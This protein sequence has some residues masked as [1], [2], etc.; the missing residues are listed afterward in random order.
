MI[1]DT[2]SLRAF[3]DRCTDYDF[4]TIDTEFHRER[5]YYSQLCL[6]QIA[7][8]GDGDESAVL[9]DTL[10]PDLELAP[11]YDLFA[12]PDVV[13]VFHAARQDLEIFFVEAG[14]F[15]KP[16]FDTQVAAMVCGFGE[17][18]GYETLVRKI[19]KASLDKSSR[20]TDWTQRPLT[21]KQQAYALAD[22]THLRGIYTF[23]KDELEKTNREHWV[24]EELAGLTS[25]ETYTLE[26]R[27][28]WRRIKTR[29]TNKPF[30]AIL[31]ELAQLREQ[32]ARE[33]N[34]PRNRIIKDDAILEIAG[35]KPK[36]V[37]ALGKSRLLMR[38]ARKGDLA[39]SLVAA[40]ERGLATPPNE[41]PEPAVQVFRKQGNEG[42]SELLRVLLK[43]K[44][45]EEGVAQKLIATSSDLDLLASEDNP[46]IAALK[47]WRYEVFGRDAE[48]LKAGE[49]ALSA[50]GSRVKIVEIS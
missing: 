45:E 28:A 11:L 32:K 10:S 29:N 40:I 16:F 15:P 23:L 42:L 20:F 19:S 14:V 24:E 21:E 1:K 35:S 22:V 34:V 48:R 7:H 36:N 2:D 17:Q 12:N 46:E 3:C 43:A 33:R 31:R 39:E 50:D 9:V 26:P 27:E 5:T 38:E 47:G 13:K 49:V 37:Q 8:P 25:P 18:V 30:L 4:V 41:Q 44:A 6:L